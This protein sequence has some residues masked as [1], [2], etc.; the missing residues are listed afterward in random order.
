VE[1]WSTDSRWALSWTAD[2]RAV[3]RFR[4]AGRPCPGADPRPDILILDEPTNGLIRADHRNEGADPLV[5]GTILAHESHILSEVEKTP[6][7][8]GALNGRC[9]A[10]AQWPTPRISKTGFVA[11]MRTLRILFAKEV[12]ATL[13]SPMVHGAAV[14]LLVLAIRSA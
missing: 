6:T 2:A 10:F 7:G 3:A 13:T 9:S 8:G 4:Q 11:D 14:F 12:N 5:P 1:R